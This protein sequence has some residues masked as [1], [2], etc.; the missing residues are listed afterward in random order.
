MLYSEHPLLKRQTDPAYNAFCYNTPDKRRLSSC[1]VVK[2]NQ[3]ARR[4]RRSSC[5][6]YDWHTERKEV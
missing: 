4:W 1:M 3:C 2:V 5:N 6:H